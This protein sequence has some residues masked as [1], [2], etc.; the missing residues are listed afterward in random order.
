[1]KPHEAPRRLVPR[2]VL[3]AE[4]RMAGLLFLLF[5]IHLAEAFF[6]VPFRGHESSVQNVLYGLVV[7]A[8]FNTVLAVF[9]LSVRRDLKGRG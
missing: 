2:A 5:L 1:M 9:V 4:L 8:P 7:T 3:R 6:T